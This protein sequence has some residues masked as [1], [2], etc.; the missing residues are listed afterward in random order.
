MKIANIII[1]ICLC[2]LFLTALVMF[3]SCA[4]EVPATKKEIDKETEMNP[5]LLLQL[6]NSYRALGCNC[7]SE[8]RFAAT[9]SVAWN[10]KLEQA[11]IDHSEDM[12]T[13]KFLSHTGSDGSNPGTR[14]KRHGYD[15]K[16]Y[17]EN[18]ARGYQT[19]KSVIEGWIKSPGHCRNIMNPNYKEMGAARKGNYWTLVLGAR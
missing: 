3:G 1:K 4:K 2:V 13:N 14:I 19:E 15:C 7:G 6:V 12:F 11:A 8:G 9:A 16:T 18:I 10:D 5:K 17:G